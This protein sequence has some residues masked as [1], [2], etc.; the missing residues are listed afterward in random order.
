MLENRYPEAIVRLSAEENYLVK[1]AYTLYLL[2]IQKGLP[3]G[4][5]A[6]TFCF[7]PTKSL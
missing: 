6:G 2:K 1:K 4:R 7:P 3:L 5:W